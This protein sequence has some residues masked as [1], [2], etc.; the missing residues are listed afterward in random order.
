VYGG[1][2]SPK[3]AD[4]SAKVFQALTRLGNRESESRSAVDL[5]LPRVG[6]AADTEAL[7]R[8]SLLVLSGSVSAR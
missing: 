8:A 3:T 6:A 1:A 5:V 4:T 7:L 2:V